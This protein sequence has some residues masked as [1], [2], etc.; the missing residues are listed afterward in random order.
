MRHPRLPSTMIIA[1]AFAVVG[2]LA[3]VSVPAQQGPAQSQAPA[4]PQ[5]PAP[6]KPG[7]Y[8][9]VA[10]KL[11]AP[12]S[13]ASFEAF[14][15][16]LADI[17]KKKDRAAL[18]RLLAANFFWIPEDAD[19]AD[20]TKPAID[21]LAKAI[22]LDGKDGFGWD[23]ITEYAGDNTGN[24]DP[25][26]AGYRLDHLLRRNAAAGRHGCTRQ[27]E[28]NGRN[29]PK[30]PTGCPNYPPSLARRRP[31][32]SKIAVSGCKVRSDPTD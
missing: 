17:A 14:R 9:V 11:P 28:V 8:S 19:V 13:D 12:V 21:N 27:P 7:P 5:A 31:G 20:K 18:A 29:S 24:P 26:R 32:T 16:Q 23:V 2:V 3:P 30:R 25:Q 22:G 10:I 4:P 6:A 15:K 1:T